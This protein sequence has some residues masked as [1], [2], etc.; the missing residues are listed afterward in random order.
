VWIDAKF[1]RGVFIK[2]DSQ[3]NLILQVESIGTT[4]SNNIEI[5]ASSYNVV[6]LCDVTST[7]GNGIEIYD[8]AGGD[9]IGNTVS[10]NWF[11]GAAA[12]GVASFGS[13]DTVIENNTI[14]GGTTAGIYATNSEVTPATSGSGLLIRGN[15]VRATAIGATAGIYVSDSNGGTGP[16]D[17]AIQSNHVTGSGGV[18]NVSGIYVTGTGVTRATIQGN[19]S[20]SNGGPG[21]V[22]DGVHAAVIGNIVLNNSLVGVGSQN[23]ISIGAGLATPDAVV[24]G[25]DCSDTQTTH[26]QQFGLYIGANATDAVVI[27][28]KGFGNTSWGVYDAGTRTVRAHN[29]QDFA[30]SSL[31]PNVAAAANVQ[32]R[33]TVTYSASMTPNAWNGNEFVI[34]ATNGSAFTIN[35]P[36]NG[37]TGQRITVR[38]KNTAGTALGAATWGAGYKMATWTNP[39][40]TF[41]RSIDFQYDGVNWIET[42]RTTADVPN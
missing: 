41:S 9:C 17:V 18:T 32:L 33:T 30:S 36:S 8:N 28:N 35:V 38:V 19:T 34:T 25:N 31:L 4:N 7:G 22:V 10:R 26:T 3:R 2:G 6:D 13:V 40:D 27:G 5:N 39:A 42:S 11:H 1:G 14:E 15:R 29:R 12:S 20:S 24:I 21:I 23:G 37:T 16:D